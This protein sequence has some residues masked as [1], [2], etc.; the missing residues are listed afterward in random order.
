MARGRNPSLSHCRGCRPE[1]LCS[2]GRPRSLPV[3]T[4]QAH[5]FRKDSRDQNSPMSE[6]V[7]WRYRGTDKECER[8]RY[9]KPSNDGR[10]P[11]RRFLWAGQEEFSFVSEVPASTLSQV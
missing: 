9:F 3:L 2:I 6:K 8:G 5:V 1:L 11:L 4:K 7:T 10:L